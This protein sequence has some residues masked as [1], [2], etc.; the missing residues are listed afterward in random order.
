MRRWIT[1]CACI[2]ALLAMPFAVT[3]AVIGDENATATPMG[4]AGPMDNQTANMS[5][6]AYISEDENLTRLAEAI[7]AAG[8]YDTLNGAGPYTIFAPSNEA[9][10]AL[11]NE[12]VN[13]LMNESDNL[14]MVLQYHV[15]DG[16]YTA[17]EI[18][19]MAANQTGDQNQTAGNESEGGV[20]DIFSGLLGMGSES[21]N[22]ST[23][24]TL[25]GEDLNVTVVDGEVMVEDAVVTVADINATNGV[26][27]IIDQ[28][29]VPPGANLTVTEDETVTPMGETTP[30]TA[31]N[32]TG[33]VGVVQ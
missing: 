13:Q 8:F 7:S 33:L 17:E 23:L 29:L 3:A 18:S 25:A 32:G 28:V 16:E 21:E 31:E 2:L 27:H 14:T 5:I 12:T 11:G 1:L 22:M 30:A 9:F 24:T 19:I 4:E 26:I 6:A 10:N 15:V 20:L